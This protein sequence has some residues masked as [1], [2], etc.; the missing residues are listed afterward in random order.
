MRFCSVSHVNPLPLSESVLCKFVSCLADESLQHRK[1]KTYVPVWSK[2]RANKGRT[3]RS[4]S[5]ADASVGLCFEGRETR[6][7]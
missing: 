5:V 7:S 6:A 2:I 3:R 1:I 4:V